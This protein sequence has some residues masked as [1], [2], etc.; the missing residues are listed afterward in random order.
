MKQLKLSILPW[1]VAL[2]LFSATKTLA[3]PAGT[4]AKLNEKASYDL[5]KRILPAYADRFLVEEV[6]AD[7]D[8]DVFELE[9]KGN[10]IVLRGNNGVSVASALNHWLKNYAHCEISWNGTNLNIP[11]PFPMVPAKVRKATPHDYRHY[12]NYCTINYTSSWW[13]WKRW[14]WEIDFMALNGV[15]MPLAMIGQNALWDRVY[16]SMGFDDKDMDAFFTGPA[17]FMWFWAGNI[18]G[19]NGPLPKSWMSSHEALEKKILA[20]ERELGMKPILP[21]FSGHVPP[22][23]KSR[24]P[25][26]KVDKLNWEGRFADTYV[27]HPDDPLF[28]QI[29]DKFMAEQDKTFGNADHLY[30]ADTFNEMYL[31]YT[32]TAYVRKIGTAVYQGMAKADPKAVWVMQGWMFWDKRDFWKPDVVKNYL[33]GVPDDKLIILDLF[34]D[35]QPIWTKTD[36]FW[37]K[38]WIWCMLHNFG[39]RNP[40][41]GNL[42]YIGREPAEMVHDPNRGRLSGI[43]LVP[44]GIEQNPVIYSLM[45]EH[46]WNDRPIDVKKWLVDYTRSRYGKRHPETEKAWSVLHKTVYAQE[47]SYET[48]ISGRPTHEPDAG[49]TITALPYDADKL[50][51]AW[52]HLL[53]AADAFKQVDGYQYDLVNVGRQVMANYATALQRQFAKDFKQKNLAAYKQR[54]AAFMTLIADMDK[55]MA[56]RPDFLLGKWLNDAKKWATNEKESR[57]YEM[58]ARDLVTLWGG[59]DASLHEYANKQWSGLFNGFYGKRWQQFFAAT[60]AA[61]AQRKS[62]DQEAFEERIKD[63]EWNWVNGR[64]QYADKPAGDPVAVSREMY[65]KYAAKIARIYSENPQLKK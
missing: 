29:A 61:L 37:G 16:R 35:E 51:P 25:N 39:G 58:N 32:D 59:K 22:T 18:D 30:G 26:A 12:L 8:K 24:F 28:Q 44:E 11:K 63:W 62:F 7:H 57:L 40:L 19:L 64:E 38:Q 41:F 43:G 13:D 56:T 21:A 53:N 55:L 15:N 9:T 47:G 10:K 27:L 14:E 23:F 4:A 34:A 36:A 50:L 20:R 45:L 46:V 48:I 60:T 65:K 2:L 52:T 42:D 49:W 5:I 3:Q 31:P 1:L 6:P 33:S 17:Y 54:T